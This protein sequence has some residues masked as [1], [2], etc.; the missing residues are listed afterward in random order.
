MPALKDISCQ[1]KGCCPQRTNRVHAFAL[2][3]LCTCIVAVLLLEMYHSHAA[4]SAWDLW[5]TGYDKPASKRPTLCAALYVGSAQCG[6]SK[7]EHIV[8]IA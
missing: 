1:L 7:C 6:N 8:I 4:E 2:E 5:T 3:G